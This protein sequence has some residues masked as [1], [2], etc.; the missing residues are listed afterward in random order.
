MR[1]N[2]KRV[3]DGTRTHDNPMHRRTSSNAEKAE[4]HRDFSQFTRGPG[5]LQVAAK[6]CEKTAGEALGRGVDHGS[7]GERL[8][9]VASASDGRI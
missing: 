8:R 1:A 9:C 4:K 2:E 5:A 7:L 6:K 3:G